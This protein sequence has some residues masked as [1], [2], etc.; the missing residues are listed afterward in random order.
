MRK[1]I[2]YQNT[3]YYVTP[4]QNF[5]LLNLFKNKHSKEQNFLTLLYGQLQ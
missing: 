3:I 2:D 5:H 1:K 4:S